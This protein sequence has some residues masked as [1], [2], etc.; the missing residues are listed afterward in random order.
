M[1]LMTDPAAKSVAP[2]A[3]QPTIGGLDDGAVDRL[4]TR[5]MRGD[6]DAYAEL[7][8]LRCDL[9]DGEARR[10]LGR[11]SDLGADVA[12]DAWVRVARAPRRCGSVVSLDAWLRRIVRSAAID[13]LRT[14]LAQRNRERRVAQTRPEAVAFLDDFE[15]LQQLRQDARRVAGLSGEEQS[16][17]E[18]LIR[19]QGTVAQLAGWM[20]LGPAAVDSRLRRAAER[21][22]ARRSEDA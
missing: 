3:G 2:R 6:R 7:F 8:H 17:F 15:L 21:A 13:M 10:S 22:R 5:M 12:Q 20:G 19:S 1:P 16:M 9:V 11:R 14:E 18:L 4:T